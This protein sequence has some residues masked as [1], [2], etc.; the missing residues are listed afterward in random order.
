MSISVFNLIKN[1]F[2]LI[3]ECGRSYPGAAKG[4]KIMRLF[5]ADLSQTC[6]TGICCSFTRTTVDIPVNSENIHEVRRVMCKP[7]KMV[8]SV[9]VSHLLFSIKATFSLYTTV[10]C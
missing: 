1:H 10:F 9:I 5:L 3:S 4:E 8:F 7:F 2:N 6:L